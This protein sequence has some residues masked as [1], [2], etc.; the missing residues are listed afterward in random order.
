M[1][2][3]GQYYFSKSFSQKLSVFSSS[4]SKIRLVMNFSEFQFFITNYCTHCKSELKTL[5]STRE[6]IPIYSLELNQPLTHDRTSSFLFHL[7]TQ[8]IYSIPPNQSKYLQYLKLMKIR[9]FRFCQI[10]FRS[11]IIVYISEY[12]RGDLIKYHLVPWRIQPQ[13]PAFV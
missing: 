12:G 4:S 8:H 6:F 7:N 9:G 3:L 13:T 2:F 1:I 5:T 10:I 11:H